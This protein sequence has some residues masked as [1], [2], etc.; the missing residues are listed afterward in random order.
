MT[1]MQRTLTS[2]GHQEPDRVPLLLLPVLQG[3]RELG[4]SIE[5]YFAKP[6]QVAEGQLRLR[7]KIGHDC[8]YTFYYA[9]IETEA[10]GGTAIFR[11]D[12]PPNAGAP[13][14]RRFEDIKH[15]T[16]PRVED[17][18]SL[19]KVLETTRRLAE[20]ARGEVPIIGV[21]M[22]PFSLPV[23]QL[24]F[25]PYLVLMHE[26]PELFEHLMRLNEEFCVAWANAQV[27]AGANA[28]CYFDPISSSTIVPR[29][30]F[31]ATGFEIA[32]RTLA[33]FEAPAAMH[34]ASGRIAPIVDDLPATGAALLGV[35]WQD[36]L[37]ALKG[38]C[39]GKVSL[40]G[41]LNGIAMRHWTPE[42]AEA[43]VK[44]AIA[45]AGPGGGFLLG[46]NH[47][48]IPWQVPDAVLMAI[49]EAVERWGRYPLDWCRVE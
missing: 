5:D 21:V 3:A 2:L 11:E 40:L 43:E 9:A 25:E 45:A 22:S 35:S 31:L 39:R 29:E 24:G 42:Q 13:V 18:P 12:G 44:A 8:L 48:E 6:E 49:A 1:S 46:D 23:I 26:H 10:W 47:G 27:A 16:P 20:Q 37:S 4:L 38:A 7:E 19:L 34:F 15:L 33:R 17:S 32:R 36:D 28:I 14:I 41:N 30:R